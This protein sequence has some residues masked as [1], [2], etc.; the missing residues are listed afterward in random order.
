VQITVPS[1]RLAR[2]LTLGAAF[3]ILA[4]FAV[5]FLKK[6]LPGLPFKNYQLINL[7][8]ATSLPSWYSA[9][10]L[11]ICS[12]LLGLIAAA[13]R[14]LGEPRSLHWLFLALI[15]LY[16]SMDEAVELHERLIKPLRAALDASGVFYFAWVIPG[17]ILVVLLGLTYLRFLLALPARTRNLVAL[18]AGLYVGGGLIVEMLGGWYASSHGLA[19]FSYRFITCFE[20]S[21]ELAGV[22]VFIH[23][24]LDYARRQWP[25]LSI[26]LDD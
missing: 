23:A 17:G 18:S 12:A 21:L 14:K 3:I 5:P 11:L 6:Y 19:N 4:G 20:E 24:L 15:F 7:D 25:D 26:R 10:A 16:L 9:A 1:S 2:I 13:K 8:E 22:I